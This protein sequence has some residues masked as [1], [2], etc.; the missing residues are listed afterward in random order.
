LNLTYEVTATGVRVT[1]QGSVHQD[2]AVTLRGICAG[3]HEPYRPPLEFYT[4]RERSSAD[5]EVR[6]HHGQVLDAEIVWNLRAQGGRWFITDDEA[7]VH[8]TQELICQR[9][10]L[11][12]SAPTCS[13]LAIGVFVS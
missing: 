8:I 11:N 3:L 5:P 7:T 9:R 12:S 10:F 6:E 1:D 4:I 13:P 2:H